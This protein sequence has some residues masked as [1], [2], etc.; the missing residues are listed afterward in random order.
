MRLWEASWRPSTVSSVASGPMNNS[1]HKKQLHLLFFSIRKPFSLALSLYSPPR[2]TTTKTM[3]RAYN[4]ATGFVA[5]IATLFTWVASLHCD[6]YST[7]VGSTT[8]HVGIWHVETE[9][10]CMRTGS[11]ENNAWQFSRAMT[12]FAMILSVPILFMT[13]LPRKGGRPCLALSHI[14]LSILNFLFLVLLASTICQSVHCQLRADGI[15]AILGGVLWL[16]S[17]AMVAVGG[18]DDAE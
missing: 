3:S 7:T 6:F 4:F 17:A 15:L 8:F 9:T 12:V 16:V 13:F 18:D 1:T 14:V 2:H 10:G 11:V 5:L